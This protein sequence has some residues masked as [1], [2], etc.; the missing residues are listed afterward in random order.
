MT[1]YPIFSSKYVFI[2]TLATGRKGTNGQTKPGKKI[3]WKYLNDIVTHL[4]R[5]TRQ[6]ANQW[7]RKQNKQRIHV[8]NL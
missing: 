5:T 2:R 6:L 3:D 4:Q 8:Q 7:S 1:T